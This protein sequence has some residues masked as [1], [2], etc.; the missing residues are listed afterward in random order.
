MIMKLKQLGYRKII[1]W[2]WLLVGVGWSIAYQLVRGQAML[3][4]DM[5][6][7]MVYANAL[8]HEHSIIGL[9][10]NWLYSTELDFFDI[11]WIFRIGLLLSPQNWH[12]ARTISM[13]IAMILISYGVWLVFYSVNMRE[14]G[15]WAAAFTV[16][17]GGGWYFWQNIYGGFYLSYIF[18]ILYS[19]AL[20]IL[21]VRDLNTNRSKV[22]VLLLLLLGFCGGIKG[23]RA[24]MLYYIPSILAAGVVMF[25]NI[26]TKKRGN[27]NISWKAI[28]CDKPCIFFGLSFLTCLSSLLGY[29]LNV[30][31][32]SQIYKYDHYDETKVAGGSFLE[33]LRYFIW[34]YGFADGKSFMSIWGIA[35]ICGVI[36][37]VFVIISGVVLITDM[38]RF[39]VEQQWLVSLSV[40]CI[41]FC[42][43]IFSYVENGAINYY[44]PLIPL[45]YF[46]L[47]IEAYTEDFV[48]E[49]SRFIILNIV[50]AV[51][52][53]ISI[54]T[55]HN[56]T[57]GPCHEY[58][59]QSEEFNDI[60]TW[61]R[62]GYKEGISQF[63][64]ANLITELSDGEIEMWIIDTFD[65]DKMY[66]YLQKADHLENY[67]SGRYFVLFEKKAGEDGDFLEGYIQNFLEKHPGLTEIYN[68]EEYVVYGTP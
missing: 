31:C 46:L 15:I 65:S 38:K 62:G 5:S 33:Q 49:R 32:L 50:I 39:C 24:I 66:E 3:D 59:A 22:Y 52:L 18:I 45:G 48:F 68:D 42:V 29:I 2:I 55:V 6:S 23:V 17:P 60:V 36:F 40:I 54:A 28:I 43:F 56:E 7:E 47:L 58:R 25:I 64:T 26:R 63:W 44:Q 21:A 34:N 19:I 30:I 37:G 12:L 8:N 57:D 10:R 14:L 20:S 67:P 13:A 4:S 27:A 51:L 41:L 35:S 53:F 16:F 11:A 61:L 1:P 9:S